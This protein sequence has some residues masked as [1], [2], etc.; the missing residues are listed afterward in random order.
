VT[1][2]QVFQQLGANNANAGG[3]FY[4]QGGQFYY[5][6]GLGLVRNLKDI[7]NIVLATHNGIP[8]YVHDLAKVE[9]GTPHALGSLAS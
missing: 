4:S 8:T 5:I 1:V 6:R 3:G 9:S 2:P 7:G